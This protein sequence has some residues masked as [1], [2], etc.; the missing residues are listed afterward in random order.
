M[1]QHY[2]FSGLQQRRQK[3]PLIALGFLAAIFAV[4]FGFVGQSKHLVLIITMGFLVTAGNMA[5]GFVL[6]S[7]TAESYPTRMRNTATGFFNALARL[8][9][10]MS[11]RVISLVQ[12]GYGFM[13]VM[14]SVAF[15]LLLP[16][17]LWGQRT[18]GK[19][20]EEIE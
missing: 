10:S 18:G 4:A 15:L 13:G 9:V 20:L 11:Q 5:M 19:S 2:F 14:F 8:S 17:L 6:I 3:N 12:A 1:R 7:Y 16:L